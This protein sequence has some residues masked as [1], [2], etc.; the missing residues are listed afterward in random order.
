MAAHRTGDPV[1]APS[2]EAPSG[3]WWIWIVLFIGTIL[4][5]SRWVKSSR[6]EESSAEPENPFQPISLEPMAPR[7]TH[8]ESDTSRLIGP[9]EF[10]KVVGEVPRQ[11]EPVSNAPAPKP[12]AE[13]FIYAAAHDLREPLRKVRLFLNRFEQKV[14]ADDLANVRG[15][16]E[17]IRLTVN[18][19]QSLLDSLLS[20]ARIEG[21]GMVFELTDLGSVINQV[22]G[23]LETCIAETRAEITVEGKLPELAADRIQLQQLVQNLIS[24]A[25]KFH[26]NGEVP[27]IRIETT[28]GQDRPVNDHPNDR[29]WCELSIRD[30]G[31]GFE[32]EYWD[33][34]LQGF[35]RLHSREQYEG[36]GLGLAICR[37]IVERHQGTL[38][39]SSAPGQGTTIRVRLPLH[40]HARS[41]DTTV[42]IG[43]KL[44]SSAVTRPAEEKQ[45]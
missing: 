16:V 30:E 5:L 15:E 7:T 28:L 4:F 34:M 11:L 37:C 12:T 35:Q 38:S 24:N 36:T 26:K 21:K 14:T 2:P 1:P 27:K 44:G 20:L 45:Y 40:Q 22:L 10:R 29:S 33:Q 42:L 17:G 6:G 18:R 43:P 25:L 39:A 32:E 13:N 23:D 8:A 19:M 41:G 9:K 3:Q 31:I